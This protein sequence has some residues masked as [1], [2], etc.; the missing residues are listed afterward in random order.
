[1]LERSVY[2]QGRVWP[3]QTGKLEFLRNKRAARHEPT[4]SVPAVLEDPSDVQEELL[5]APGIPQDG[6]SARVSSLDL[7]SA[8]APSEDGR[9]ADEREESDDD[10]SVKSEKSS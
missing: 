8:S 9:R 3:D 7:E 10:S 1:M 4:D 5:D 6:L 2:V